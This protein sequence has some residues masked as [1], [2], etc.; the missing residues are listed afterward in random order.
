MVHLEKIQYSEN[1]KKAERAESYDTKYERELHKRVSTWRELRVLRALLGTVGQVER[2]LDVPCGA[3]RLSPLFAEHARD[4]FEVDFSREMLKLCRENATSYRAIIAA[5]SAFQLPFPDRAFDLVLSIR[6]SHHIPLREARIDHLR[7]LLRVSRRFVLVTFFAEESVK[8][9]LRNLYRRLGGKKRPKLT[10]SAADV[11]AA[12]GERGF[13]VLAT[14][15]ISRV[16]S[17]HYFTLL[18]KPAR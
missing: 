3:G 18:E 8:N 17:G 7:E 10:L 5:A 15:S 2:A 11:A 4:L 12:A 1:R 16:F 13:R 14:K 6:L 9:R